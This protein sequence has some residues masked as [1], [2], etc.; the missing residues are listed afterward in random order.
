MKSFD[1]FLHGTGS[2]QKGV[3]HELF[4]AFA[5][6]AWVYPNNFEILYV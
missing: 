5:A 4:A 3:G 1:P 6:Y 2:E